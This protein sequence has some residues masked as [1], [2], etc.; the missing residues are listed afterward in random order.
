[1]VS[2]S[3]YHFGPHNAN[4]AASSQSTNRSYS[5]SPD[6]GTH[7]TTP[8]RP[9]TLRP[10]GSEGGG[11]PLLGNYDGDI[12][13][14]HNTMPRLNSSDSH[15][16]PSAQP[17]YRSG[18]PTPSSVESHTP[19]ALAMNAPPAPQASINS[20][21]GYGPSA[22]GAAGATPF[23]E[24]GWS[25][26]S[27]NNGSGSLAPTISDKFS[28]SPDP[29]SWGAHVALNE[30]EADDYL[31][32]PDP[33]RDRKSD[34]GGTIFTVRGFY[35]V[36]CILLLVLA[37]ITLFAGFPIIVR[38]TGDEP[39]NNGAYNLGGINATGQVAA[40]L[41]DFNLI[42]PDTPEDAYVWRSM[43]SGEDWDLI[44]SDEFN[45]DGRTFW[46]G[47]DPFWEAENLHYWGTNNLEWYDPRAIITEGG[48][49]KITLDTIPQRGLN[50]TGGIMSTWNKFCFR[51]G[52]IDVS[53]SL[54]GRSDIYGLW[55][56][57]WTM[58][59][60]GRMGY[61]G[62]LEGMWPYSY[63]SCDVGTLPN[64]TYPTGESF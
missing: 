47:D 40:R 63:N 12:Y 11:S 52:Y 51:G 4:A 56:A 26:Q 6:V 43:R 3:S 44:F 28:L 62:T 54:P 36:G 31:H 5:R 14:G 61:G 21:G 53:V 55:P 48:N 7:T 22:T 49:L 23:G 24:K 37:L 29:T 1:M 8:S 41:G 16:S 2:G 50:Y 64:Q 58:G 45:K 10:G 27:P 18:S 15:L 32:N 30:P 60:L 57:V 42:D 9:F 17:L 39:T 38:F 34:Q 59:N 25:A 20:R 19:Y 33:K 46:P 13:A 35:N